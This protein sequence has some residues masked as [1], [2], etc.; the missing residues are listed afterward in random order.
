MRRALAVLL[1][2]VLMFLGGPRAP[3]APGWPVV[4]PASAAGPEPPPVHVLHVEGPIVPVVASFVERGLA[5]AERAG[6][7]CVIRLNTPGGLY[8]TT[9][10][11][12]TRIVNARVPVIV[13]VAP[14]GG[15]AASAGTF[16]TVAAHVAAMAPGT[17]IGAA[18][19]VAAQPGGL[20]ETEGQKVTEDA[21]AWI[22]SLA[23]LRGRDAALAE[24]AVRESRSYTDTEAVER[25]LVDLRA[26]D[27]EAL[28]GALDGRTVTV[29]QGRE[30]TLR[31]AGAEVRPVSMTWSEQFLHTI[32]NPNVAYLLLTLGAVGLMT[33]FYYP[34]AVFPGVAG[35]LSLLLGLYA[36]GTLNAY[37]GGL[38]LMLLAFGLFMAEIF[39]TTHGVLGLGGLVAFVL[40]SVL[41]FSGGPPG[42][43]VSISLIAAAAVSLGAFFALLVGAAVRAHRRRVET[44]AEGLSGRV[45]RTLT[46]LDPEGLVLVEGER[47]AA[48]EET[49]AA[50]P[51][52][53]EVVVTGTEGLRLRVKRRGAAE[54]NLKGRNGNA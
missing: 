40:G 54:E 22:R 44:G 37:W 46:A 50:V 43:R 42:I 24:A 18:H 38:L 51:A 27:L 34:G 25:G 2:P 52:G 33:E 47:W 39:A 8:D 36:L 16:I 45:A 20:S 4:P 17:R 28:L 19:P 35:A 13:Y 21:A 5:G 15:W 9:Q 29:A 48:R 6:A 14:S 26:G 10:R 12:V 32:T 41:L 7:P 3:A 53:E 30:W 1:L 49:G 23:A 11:I 31:T